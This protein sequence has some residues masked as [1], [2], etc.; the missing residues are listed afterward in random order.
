MTSFSLWYFSLLL[1]VNKC[2]SLLNRKNIRFSWNK[3]WV[4]ESRFKRAWKGCTIEPKYGKERSKPMS[5]HTGQNLSMLCLRNYNYQS[6]TY[7]SDSNSKYVIFKENIESYSFFLLFKNYS[8][9]IFL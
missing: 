6:F 1:K 4:A 7:C 9:E 3:K 5:G 8:L 2:Y